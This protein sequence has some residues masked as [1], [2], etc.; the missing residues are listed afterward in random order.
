MTTAWIFAGQGAQ[1]VGMGRDLAAAWPECKAL[2]DKANEVL[3]YDLAGLC[4]N[5]P[6]AELTKTNHCQPAIFLVTA[7]CLEAWKKTG[8]AGAPVAVAGLS[9]GE[10]SALYAAGCLSF[11]DTLRIL[12]ARGRLMQEACDATQGAMIS[13]IGMADEAVIKIAAQAKVSVANLNSPGQIVLSGS[14]EAIQEAEKL[15]K[16]AG[17]RKTV[18]LP[19]AGAY[20]SPLMQSAAEGLREVLRAVTFKAPAFPVISNVTGK[21]HGGPDEIRELMVRQV[22][23][24]VQWIETVQGLKASGVKSYVEFGPG[25]ILT[26]LVKRMDDTASLANMSDVPS[27]VK[28]LSASA[29][30]AAPA[31]APA[32]AAPTTA[33]RLAGKAAL[34]TGASRGIGKA[35]AMRLAAEGADVAL[36]G[37]QAA[38]LE[39]TAAAIRA[40]GRKAAVCVSDVSR[41]EDAKKTVEAALTA[42]GRL[43]ILVNN[44]GITKD[45]LI[46]RMADDDWDAVLDTN[47][48]GAFAFI[49]AVARPMMKQESGV[50]I[51]VSSVIGIMGNAGQCNYAAAKGGLIALTKSAARELAP[52]HIRVN[53]VAPGFVRTK[54][55]EGLT[56]ELKTRMLDTIPLKRFGSSEDIAGVVAFLAGEDAAYMTG[57]TLAVC[58]G[59]VMQ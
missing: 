28:A 54:M 53:A 15:A 13:V 16:E 17:A 38:T 25:A 34:V 26:G 56:E 50:I 55:T 58:G 32:A 4:F 41:S 18:R 3:G 33:G 9:L 23:S 35:I 5:G 21:P 59:L 39:E 7:A 24:S 44:A 27:L 2:F 46:A 12:A 6:M 19:V 37:R 30:P 1:S 43:D 52:R 20:H 45:G 51:N 49:K 36:V 42:L 48:K 8:Q 11:E 14:A 22:T 29:K 57:Q 31:A 40:L 47:L 10:W